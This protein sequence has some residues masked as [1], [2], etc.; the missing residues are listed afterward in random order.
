MHVDVYLISKVGSLGYIVIML[1]ADIVIVARQ[2]CLWVSYCVPVACFSG[3]RL[4][5]IPMTTTNFLLTLN[6]YRIK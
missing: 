3:R 6:T 4:L 2:L 1:P 5:D